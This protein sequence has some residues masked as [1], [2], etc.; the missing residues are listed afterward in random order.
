[1]TFTSLYARDVVGLVL[2][3]ASHPKQFERFREV[4]GKSLQPT[5]ETISLGARLA[6][7]GLVRLLPS[8]TTPS[9]WPKDV[10]RITPAFLPTSLRALARETD[11]IPATLLSEARATALGDRPLV[12]LTAGL[13]QSSEALRTMG[14]TKEQGF[15]LAETSRQLHDDQASWSSSG[16]HEI[17]PNATHYIQFDRPDVVIR[18]VREVVTR[19]RTP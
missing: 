17:V 7:T 13:G 14:L 19:T 12:V 2:V 11:A 18:A 10:G 6:W 1:M 5:S 16:R 4:A 9:S 8:D 3:D 15:Q